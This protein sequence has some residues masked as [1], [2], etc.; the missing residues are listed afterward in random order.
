MREGQRE[1]NS[2]PHA[3]AAG[4][5]DDRSFPVNRLSRNWAVVERSAQNWTS[6]TFEE[7][8]PDAIPTKW[9]TPV[10][11]IDCLDPAQGEPA[12]PPR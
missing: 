11:S 4:Q 2:C 7:P 6:R 5:S 9:I 12:I 3:A 8:A 1:R 10:L